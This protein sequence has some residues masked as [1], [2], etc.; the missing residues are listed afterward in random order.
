VLEQYRYPIAGTAPMNTSTPHRF[1]IYSGIHKALRAFMADTLVRVGRMD[2]ADTT[3][4]ASTMQRVLRLLDLCRAHANHENRFI[5]PMLEI[6]AP[7]TSR[8]VAYDHADHDEEA[9]RLVAAAIALPGCAAELRGAAAAALYRALALFTASNFEHQYLEETVHNAVL[10]AHCSDAEI[11]SLH[12]NLVASTEP[13][14]LLFILRWLVPSLPAQ[15]RAATMRKLRSDAP[16]AAFQKAL[17]LVRAHL[18]QREWVKLE[19]SLADAQLGLA[20]A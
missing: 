16:P 4:L 17:D 10:W 12:D 13:Q 11:M 3:D 1:D 7:G 15:E 2:P 19:T 20:A 14:E 8:A 6:H 18:T 9:S 5:H